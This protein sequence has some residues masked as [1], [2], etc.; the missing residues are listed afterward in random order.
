L[1]LAHEQR[2]VV[3]VKVA[4]GM[5]DQLDRYLVCAWI[6]GKRAGREL[7]KLL[8]VALGKICPDLTDV[9]LNDVEIVQ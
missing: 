9:L 6:P 4:L 3:E 7:G 5:R 2:D 8:V 1:I